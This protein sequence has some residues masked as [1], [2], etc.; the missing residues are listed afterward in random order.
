MRNLNL[1]ARRLMT[2][3][4]VLAQTNKPKDQYKLT[5]WPEYNAGLKRRGSLALWI[6]ESVSPCSHRVWVFSTFS[7]G[8]VLTQRL[9]LGHPCHPTNQMVVA[10]LHH[11]RNVLKKAILPYMMFHHSTSLCVLKTD[12]KPQRLNL[13]TYGTRFR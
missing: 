7:T 3:V 9:H 12:L 5:N 1:T 13:I 8:Q 2:K 10:D 4:D 6:D 11:I